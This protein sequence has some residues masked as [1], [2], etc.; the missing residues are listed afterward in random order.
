MS[1]TVFLLGAGASVDAG[2][3]AS[4]QMSE[5]ISAAILSSRNQYSG[6]VHAFNYAVGALIAHRSA[7]G[8]DPYSGIDVERLFSAVQMLG[9]RDLVEVAPFVTWSPVL[10][11]IGPTKRVS[12]SFDRDFAQI[13]TGKG[14]KKPSQL[15][16]ELVSSM[17]D[18]DVSEAVFQRLEVEMLNALTQ[19]LK[20]DDQKLDYLS[21]LF[22][23][24]SDT[25]N[26]A[27]LNY[28][29]SVETLAQAKGL[30][31]DTGI[32]SW[33]GGYDWAW[34]SSA[35]IKLLKLHGSIDWIL[36]SQIGAGGVSQQ[37]IEIEGAAESG[38][39]GAGGRPGVVFGTRGKVRADGP[40]LAMLR[41][42][43]E[44]LKGASRLIVVGYSFRDDHINVA[45]NRWINSAP[46]RTL[47]VVDPG[48]LSEASSWNNRGSYPTALA[49]ATHSF[50]R[51]VGNVR[52]LDLHV[53]S[54]TAKAGLALAVED[55]DAGIFPPPEASG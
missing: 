27:T 49:N 22:S 54:Q 53:I 52:L 26:I 47:T 11:T 31:L 46:M 1:K 13:L 51:D 9:S 10:E 7:S 18:R 48:F 6:I 12:S 33:Q 41:S 40:F 39:V 37:V 5:K 35:R 44:M 15:I 23:E 45:I 55:P 36:S 21:P 25:I 14:Y 32:T 24:P 28:D 16:Q 30:E 17:V 3:P 38:S 2:I 43:D 42:F 34:N 50:Q 8:G 20:V 4:S 19:L 29:Q